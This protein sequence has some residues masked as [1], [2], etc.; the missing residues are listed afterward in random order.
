MY[1]WPGIPLVIASTCALVAAVLTLI[2]VAALP[3]IWQGGRRVDSWT[4]LRKAYFTTTV[5]I[6]TSFSLLLAFAGGLEPW[7]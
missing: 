6:Y 4:S 3:A 2:T 5:L 1:N 7:S